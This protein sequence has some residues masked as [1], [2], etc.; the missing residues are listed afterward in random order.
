MTPVGSTLSLPAVVASAFV[1]SWITVAIPGPI[2][3]VATRLGLSRHVAAAVWFLLGVTALDVVIFGALA[4]GAAP[5]FRHLGAMPAVIVLGGVALFWAGVSSLCRPG[6]PQGREA[7]PV[8]R[9]GMLGYFSLGV[10]VSAGNPHYWVWW[11]TAGLAFIEAARSHGPAGLAWM[12]AALVGGVVAFY[13]PLL[14]ALHKG[15]SLLSPR[16][17]QIVTRGL[18]VALMLLGCGLVAVGIHRLLDRPPW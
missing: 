16:G 13:V 2:T 15:R 18:G 5:L 17:E 9:A 6:R 11:V 14:W 10:A 3:I 8:E 7:V 1:V 12:L 4:G